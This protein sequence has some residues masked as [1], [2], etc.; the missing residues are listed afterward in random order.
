MKADIKSEE[1]ITLLVHSFYDKLLLDEF[2][3]VHFHGLDLKHHFP[4]IIDFWSLILLDKMG[5]TSNVFDKHIHL[6]INQQHFDRWLQL[7]SKTVDEL[8]EGE[9]A[10]F[11][12]QRAA[13]LGYTFG[14]KMD[15]L[16]R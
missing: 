12:K 9:K 6:N 15:S 16:H 7:F 11:A 4:R 13:V 10:N 5:Y 3:A 14:S 8:F 1:D 2:M